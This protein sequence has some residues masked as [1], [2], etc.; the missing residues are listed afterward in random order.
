[1]GCRI[2]KYLSEEPYTKNN[3]L[4]NRLYIYRLATLRTPEDNIRLIV[5]VAAIK[6]IEG[7]NGS[8][9]LIKDKG[10]REVTT[11]YTLTATQMD[12]VLCLLKRMTFI[13]DVVTEWKERVQYV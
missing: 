4:K 6:R 8:N 11:I 9:I 3:M 13:E 1:M 2:N 10:I 5:L 12:E 7:L